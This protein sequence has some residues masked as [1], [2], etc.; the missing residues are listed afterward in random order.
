MGFDAKDI[1]RDLIAERLRDDAVRVSA[2][3][4]KLLRRKLL[5]ND[6]RNTREIA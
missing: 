4:N 6:S 2:R 1:D 3:D 5:K